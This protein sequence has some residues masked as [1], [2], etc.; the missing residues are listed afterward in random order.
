MQKVV[1]TL[2]L[3]F[4][5]SAD[6]LA[7]MVKANQTKGGQPISVSTGAELKR[8]I[9]KIDGARYERFTSKRGQVL[10][11]SIGFTFEEKAAKAI[12]KKHIGKTAE[13]FVLREDVGLNA[14]AK[15]NLKK[16]AALISKCRS[17]KLSGPA[18]RSGEKDDPLVKF[19]VNP[20]SKSGEATPGAGA[21]V[22]GELS[23]GSD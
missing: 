13:V 5:F 17:G 23:I 8:C 3:V 11:P 21:S 7:E 22:G 1:L 18:A 14:D 9:L 19:Q 20:T 2:L 16:I 6:V 4:L 12:C 15:N 10:I